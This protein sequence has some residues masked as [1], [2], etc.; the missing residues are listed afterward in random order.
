MKSIIYVFILVSSLLLSGLLLSSPAQASS[1][2]TYVFSDPS[3]ELR[4]HELNKILRCPKCQNQNLAD[5]NSLISQD[6]RREVKRLLEE[7]R[8]DDQ[9][10]EFMV[11]RY[12]SFVLYKPKLDKITYLLWYGPIG[13]GVFGLIMLVFVVVRQKQKRQ[14][15][16]NETSSTPQ[17]LNDKEQADIDKLLSK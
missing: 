4:F 13:F 16:T 10:T 7:G 9:I 6:L 15:P 3:Y 14:Q 2:E 11:M 17:L 1:V 5:S 12:G 8:S